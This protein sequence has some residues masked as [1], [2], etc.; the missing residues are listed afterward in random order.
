MAYSCSLPVRD[1]VQIGGG[2][3]FEKMQQNVTAVIL[4][5]G[6]RVT[7]T[8]RIDNNEVHENQMQDLSSKT[9]WKSDNNVSSDY[10]PPIVLGHWLTDYKPMEYLMIYWSTYDYRKMGITDDSIYFA[11]E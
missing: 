1:S 11:F 3:A 6:S 4:V 5:A 9:P 8:G 2:V 10:I 7:G